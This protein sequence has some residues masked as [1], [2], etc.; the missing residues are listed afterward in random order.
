MKNRKLMYVVLIILSVGA[1]VLNAVPNAVLMR[2]FD[3]TNTIYKYV[4]GFS[5]LPVGYGIWGAMAAGVCSVI[6]VILGIIGIFKERAA[7]GKWMLGIS[8]F[9]L[10]M[11][12]SLLIFGSMT[13]IGLLVTVLLASETVLLFYMGKNES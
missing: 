3:G 8:V 13:F 4:S 12:L 11:R 9:A 5:M 2:F 6:L 1:A 7:L 10:A